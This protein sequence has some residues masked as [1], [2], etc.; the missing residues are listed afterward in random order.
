[1]SR[2]RISLPCRALCAS[3]PTRPDSCCCGSCSRVCASA[4]YVGPLTLGIVAAVDD[5]L[6]AAGNV[7]HL[8]Q[9][10]WDGREHRGGRA[11]RREEGS[12][13]E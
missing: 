9:A 10:R 3:T 5:D 13:A 12:K 7:V 6:V 4:R 11:A 1:M 2:H 8:G